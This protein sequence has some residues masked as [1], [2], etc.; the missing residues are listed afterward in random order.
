MGSIQTQIPLLCSNT[1]GDQLHHQRYIK[2]LKCVR[3]TLS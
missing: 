1:P 2:E 3:K